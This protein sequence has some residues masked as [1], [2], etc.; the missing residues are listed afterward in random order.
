MDLGI[1]SPAELETMHKAHIA[2][3]ASPDKYAL[4]VSLMVHGQK[5]L[6]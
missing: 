1:M 2:L 6:Q 3:Q 4:F 5:P